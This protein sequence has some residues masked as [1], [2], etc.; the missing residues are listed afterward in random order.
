MYV[1]FNNIYN[2]T[3]NHSSIASIF[4]HNNSVIMLENEPDEIY[5]TNTNTNPVY[6]HIASSNY[7]H[8]LDEMIRQYKETPTMLV[9][10]NIYE[11]QYLLGSIISLYGIY[12]C[13]DKIVNIYDK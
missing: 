4:N 8:V 11:L 12:Y 5:I 7:L 13:I 3:T 9:G 10:V 1:S 6:L 2:E